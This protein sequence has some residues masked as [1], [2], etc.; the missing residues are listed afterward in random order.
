MGQPTH[1]YTIG[2]D[3]EKIPDSATKYE[4]S[5]ISIAGCQSSVEWYDKICH[6][7]TSNLLYHDFNDHR[8]NGICSYSDNEEQFHCLA[9]E[10]LF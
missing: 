5:S 7:V 6:G 1:R 8:Q 3:G 4:L 9:Q 2:S 10:C